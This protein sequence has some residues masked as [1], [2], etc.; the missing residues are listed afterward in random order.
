MQSI[1]LLPPCF[2][3][4]SM[5]FSAY[6]SSSIN[7]KYK[8]TETE[9]FLHQ[10]QQGLDIYSISRCLYSRAAITVTWLEPYRKSRWDLKKTVPAW[11]P[12]N[13]SELDM[14]MR[15]GQKLPPLCS[16]QRHSNVTQIWSRQTMWTHFSSQI[17]VTFIVGRKSYMYSMWTHRWEFMQLLPSPFLLHVLDTVHFYESIWAKK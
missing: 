8:I 16:T 6:S 12:K 5:F 17:W 14:V 7:V 15:N 11:N 13:I 10:K 2:T 1:T 9:V 4:A 3:V